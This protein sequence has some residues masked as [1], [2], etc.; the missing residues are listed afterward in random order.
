MPLPADKPKPSELAPPDY[1]AMKPHFE[2]GIRSVRDIAR[3]FGVSHTALSN[4]ARKHGWQ[5]NLRASIEARAD[6]IVARSTGVSLGKLD[7]A[8]NAQVAEAVAAAE[9]PGSAATVEANAR[10]LAI[11]RMTHRSDIAKART[12]CA[13]LLDELDLASDQPELFGALH[14]LFAGDA[15]LTQPVDR[16]AAQVEQL[17]AARRVADLVGALPQRASVF[18][19]LVEAMH[20][21]IGMEREAFGLDTAHGTDGRPM[22]LV[23]DLTGRSTASEEARAKSLSEY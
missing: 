7:E 3:E 13:R 9:D 1:P 10:A 22:V 2:A 6:Q 12:A 18:K 16:T 4:H 14:D 19:T 8:T 17:A 15:L 20:K 23:K 5:R 21:L 11:V